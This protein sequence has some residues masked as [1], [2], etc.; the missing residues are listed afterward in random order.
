MQEQQSA[1]PNSQEFA[2]RKIKYG[3][4]NLLENVILTHVVTHFAENLEELTT[5][6]ILK[7][8]NEV[9]AFSKMPHCLV[10]IPDYIMS[11]NIKSLVQMNGKLHQS[12]QLTA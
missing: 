1:L 5:E 4:W 3:P 6:N 11:A 9:V 10:D 8:F 2:E 12:S 7:G